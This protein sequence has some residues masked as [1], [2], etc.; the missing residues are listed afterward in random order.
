MIS[1]LVFKLATRIL[2]TNIL[3]SKFVSINLLDTNLEF[4]ILIT[5]TF[6]TNS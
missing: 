3:D 6:V 2:T 5:K 1:K 4:K